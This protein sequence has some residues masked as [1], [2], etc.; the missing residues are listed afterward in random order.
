MTVAESVEPRE[1]TADPSGDETARRLPRQAQIAAI[2][3]A[4]YI[5]EAVRK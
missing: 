1:V 4:A 5:L 3:E 2:V